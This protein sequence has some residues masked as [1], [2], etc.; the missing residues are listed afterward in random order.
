MLSI[1]RAA[2]LAI[3]LVGSS[4]QDSR[5]EEIRVIARLPAPK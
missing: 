1:R 4:A 3:V 5:T 2:L